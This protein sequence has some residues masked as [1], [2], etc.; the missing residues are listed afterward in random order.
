MNIIGYFQSKQDNLSIINRAHKKCMT[1]YLLIK[2][3]H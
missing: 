2:S 1:V 3:K